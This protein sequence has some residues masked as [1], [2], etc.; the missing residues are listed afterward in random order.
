MSFIYRDFLTP[1][2]FEWNKASALYN[3]FTKVWGR[4]TINGIDVYDSNLVYWNGVVRSD[5]PFKRFINALG[6]EYAQLTEANYKG[7][8][9]VYFTLD[10]SK[11][12][13]TAPEKTAIVADLTS[14]FTVGDEFELYVHYSGETRRVVTSHWIQKPGTIGDSISDYTIDTVG[15][16]NTLH[17]SPMK[18]FANATLESAGVLVPNSNVALSKL[19][20]TAKRTSPRA[21]P[22]TRVE[23]DEDTTHLYATLALLDNGGVFA[24]Q[25]TVYNERTT[26]TKVGESDVYF[27]YS[28]KIKYKVVTV[29]TVDSYVVGQI[30]LLSNAMA[31]ALNY[32]GGSIYAISNVATDT[33]LKEAVIAMNNIEAVGL[34]Y[35]GKLRVDAVAAMKRKDFVKMLGKIFGTGYTKK[36]AKWYE[37]VIAV[38]LIAVAVVVGVM[39]GGGLAA[40]SSSLVSAA[41]ALATTAAVLTIGMLVYASAFPNATDQTRMIG[42]VA[43]IVG[44][45]AMVTGI[46]AGIQNAFQQAA[47]EAIKKGTIQ[48]AGEYTVQQFA[49]DMFTK[50]V[51]SIKGSV[52]DKI[53]LITTPSSWSLPDLSSITMRDV[54]GWLDNLDFGMRTYMRFFGESRQYSTLTENEQATKED[55]V[56]SIFLAYEMVDNNDALY[57]MDNMVKNNLGGQKTENFMTQIA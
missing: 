10:P 57:R 55:G 11:Y 4:S 16:R 23:Y 50:L 36:K 24:Q 12:V 47:K 42:R 48:A 51:D 14:G 41:V 17:S 35:Q 38:V 5:T 49:K 7:V 43:Q 25:G 21:T 28:Y 1:A 29:P 46:M 13:Y 53:N 44:L 30:D 9:N 52:M 27:E 32:K 18:Y 56:E 20:Q 22:V 54:S 45:A 31:T 33:T 40:V 3:R 37:K 2:R 34:T 6:I 15:I 8:T 39:S 19:Q 26:V